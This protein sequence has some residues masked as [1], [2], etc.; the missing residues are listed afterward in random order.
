MDD[1]VRRFTSAT[2][3]VWDFSQLR[4]HAVGV[5]WILSETD[6][7][8]LKPLTSLFFTLILYSIKKKDGIPVTLYLDELGNTG[9]I[10][11]LEIE[12]TL[13][14]SKNISLVAGL[15]SFS[16]LASVYGQYA[17]NIFRDNFLT[18]IFLHGLDAETGEKCSRSLG[19]FTHQEET[20]SF[21][22]SENRK[23]ESKSISRNSRR[24]L[25]GDEI[26]RLSD[27]EF[28]LIH[29]N[30]KPA[31]LPKQYYDQP[32]KPATAPPALGA[33]L[34]QDFERAAEELKAIRSGRRS[35]TGAERK[36]LPPK[37]RGQ[38]EAPPRKLLP[39][40]PELPPELLEAIDVEIIEDEET[41]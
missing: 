6:M 22:Y 20:T 28:I 17:E 21:S 5:Y 27:K 31:I 35:L 38:I 30:K 29:G 7:A 16:Q 2:K 40:M 19:E 37:G 34:S 1:E 11:S 33:P 10:P 23:T 4:E 3:T 18:K 14:R 15:Q 9:R 26:R 32:P 8:L 25:T 12:V 39:P 24:L 13:L 41:D 36:Q